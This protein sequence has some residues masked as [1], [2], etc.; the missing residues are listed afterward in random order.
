[1]NT[2]LIKELLYQD[3]FL[4]I[5]SDAFIKLQN[6]EEAAIYCQFLNY[7]GYTDWRLP[8]AMEI[9]EINSFL[10]RYGMGNVGYWIESSLYNSISESYVIPVRNVVQ[11]MK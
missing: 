3:Y 2:I 10:T 7:G 4:D 9:A 1:M 8:K 11:E 6:Q 5:A